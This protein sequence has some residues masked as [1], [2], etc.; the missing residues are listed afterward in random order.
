MVFVRLGRL[1]M[2]GL[3]LVELVWESPEVICHKRQQL[4]LRVRGHLANPLE[5]C[6]SRCY[7]KVDYRWF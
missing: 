6:L 5:E 3:V 4:G 2:P 1:A 7:L